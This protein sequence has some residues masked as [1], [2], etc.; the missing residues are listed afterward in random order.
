MCGQRPYLYNGP[1]KFQ[2]K[3]SSFNVR[4]N[5]SLF[6]ACC[7]GF[8]KDTEQLNHSI[9]FHSNFEI[10]PLKNMSNTFSATMPCQNDRRRV[11]KK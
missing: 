11:L 5:K 8:Y 4:H 2:K 7:S 9:L 1:K 6:V 10:E 3:K